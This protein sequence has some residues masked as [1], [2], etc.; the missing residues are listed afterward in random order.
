MRNF[1]LGRK[2]LDIADNAPERFSMMY[3]GEEG[4]CG[5]VAC[6]AGHTMLESDYT[7]DGVHYYYRPDGTRVHDNAAE[8]A[9]LLEFEYEEGDSRNAFFATRVSW[10]RE[11]VEVSEQRHA[12]CGKPA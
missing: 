4:D 6:A 2:V 9:R 7:F 1:Q 8:A 11:M 12:R 10:F 3:W 5:T